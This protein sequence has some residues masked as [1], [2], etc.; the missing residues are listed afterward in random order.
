MEWTAPAPGITANPV[1]LQPW[2]DQLVQV[3]VIAQKGWR[4]HPHVRYAIDKVPAGHKTL[5]KR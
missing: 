2:P 1:P 4:S 5:F 3:Q